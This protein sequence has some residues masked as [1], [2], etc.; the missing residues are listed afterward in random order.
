M[1]DSVINFCL[2]VLKF[3][4]TLWIVVTIPVVIAMSIISALSESQLAPTLSFNM[5]INY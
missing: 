4:R 2:W 3:G 1:A 5:F